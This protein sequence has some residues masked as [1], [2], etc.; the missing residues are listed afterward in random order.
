MQQPNNPYAPPSASIEPT[1]T[2]NEIGELRD[3]PRHCRFGRGAGWVSEATSL[4]GKQ[5]GLFIG[6]AV[7]GFIIMTAIGMI[8]I[9]GL[10]NGL[11]QPVL[12]AGWMFACDRVRQGD[13]AKLEDLFVGFSRNLGS[14]ILVG[15]VQVGLLL[16]LGIAA[17]MMSVAFA[18][19]TGG[20]DAVMITFLVIVALF[21]GF[22]LTAPFLFAPALI[23]LHDQPLGAALRL[24]LIGC[25]RN[26]FPLLLFALIGFLMLLGGLVTLFIGMLVV[27][28]ILASA[29][30]CAY[31]NIYIASDSETA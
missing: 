2:S 22:L 21:V 30:Y 7:V 16:L 5:W 4:F 1:V 27:G 15:V 8:P 3:D 25:M 17:A 23:L 24:S 20:S 26:I 28:P 11:L 18:G 13:A 31:R 19:I 12:I 6:M 10:F 14:L 29:V 9:I